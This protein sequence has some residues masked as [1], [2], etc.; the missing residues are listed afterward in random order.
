MYVWLAGPSDFDDFKCVY[1]ALSALSD[2][3]FP[4]N[5]KILSYEKTIFDSMA[6]WYALEKNIEIEY[7][8]RKPDCVVIFSNGEQYFS[9]M[10]NHL[11]KQEL[12]VYLVDISKERGV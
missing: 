10:H 1:E 8:K 5:W 6:E 12:F 7:S 9:D 2:N 11:R 3:D 4:S